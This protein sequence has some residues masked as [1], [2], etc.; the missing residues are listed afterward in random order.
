MGR[1]SIG[2]TRISISL[3][4]Q[5]GFISGVAPPEKVQPEEMY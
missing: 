3:N 5:I 1:F 2:Y 4:K